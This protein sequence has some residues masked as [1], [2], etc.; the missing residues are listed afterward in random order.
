MDELE[1]CAR[2]IS[3]KLRPHSTVLV[4]TG[5]GVSAESGVPTFRGSGGLWA[6]RALR[7]LAEAAALMRMPRLV[8]EM[9]QALREQLAEARPNPAHYALAELEDILWPNA[10]VA[11]VTQNIDGLHQA[12]GSRTVI[13]LHGSAYR[14]SCQL[15]GAPHPCLPLRLVE[16]PPRC[17][18]G[19]IIRPDVVFFGEPVPEHAWQEALALAERADVVLVVG[20][21]LEV[22]PAAALPFVAMKHGALVVEVNL[23]PTVLTESADFALHGF[24]SHLVPALAERLRK[25]L[26]RPPKKIPVS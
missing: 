26:K 7:E 5:A 12:A 13:E 18:C 3:E 23:E 9:I 1:R 6:D 21:S 19:G 16:L 25:T 14:F 15:C 20:T 22:E 10:R 2:T 11:I 24:A 17:A 4:L 8:W